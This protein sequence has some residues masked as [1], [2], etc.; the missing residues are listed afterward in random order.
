VA[1]F[2]ALVPRFEEVEVAALDE[3]GQRFTWRVRGWPARIVQH[4]VDHLDGTLYVDRMWSRSFGTTTQ[5]SER[6]GGRAIADVR[7][8]LGL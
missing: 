6:F 5:N 8:A 4:E 3:H 2:S 1:G 7:A